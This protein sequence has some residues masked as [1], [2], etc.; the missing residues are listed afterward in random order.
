MEPKSA[1]SAPDGRSHA[2]EY[3]LLH[4]YLRDRMADRL[5]LTFGEIEDLLGF[6]LPASARIDQSWW[7]SADPAAPR[8]AQTDCWKLANRTATVS[9]RAQRVLFE[10]DQTRR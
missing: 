1:D 6:A 7:G 4:K 8:S 10:R 3:K 2:G 5:V 9:M